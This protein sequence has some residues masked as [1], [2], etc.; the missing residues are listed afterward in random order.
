MTSDNDTECK[1]ERDEDSPLLFD[2]RSG[3]RPLDMLTPRIFVGSALFTQRNKASER[4][5]IKNEPI[6]VAPGIGEITYRG[7]ELRMSDDYRVFQAIVKLVVKQYGSEKT[8][9]EK[10]KAENPN[11]TDDELKTLKNK[12]FSARY[13]LETSMYQILDTIGWDKGSK[14]YVQLRESLNRLKTTNL[15]IASYTSDKRIVSMSIIAKLSLPGK[16]NRDEKAQIE[17]DREIMMLFMQSE[18]TFLNSHAEE[19]LS[20]PAFK[21]YSFLQAKEYEPMHLEDFMRSTGNNYKELRQYKRYLIRS[22]NELIEK[23][24]VQDWDIGKED[25]IVKVMKGASK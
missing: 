14:R 24:Y 13:T 17:F 3:L 18:V 6:Y 8:I 15:S 1:N 16:N 25:K 4:Q 5:F 7:E 23:G 11:I 9:F 20:T 12:L 2:S 10:S 22:L 19:E 21:V